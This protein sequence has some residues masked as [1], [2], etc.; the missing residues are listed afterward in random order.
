MN[1]FYHGDCKFVMNHDI[2]AE[3]VDL[4][5]LDPPFFTGQVQRGT[6]KWEPGAMEISYKDTKSYWAEHLERMRQKAPAWMHSIPRSSEFKSYLFYMLERLEACKR[7]LKETGSI[8]L[9]CDWRA[10]HYLKMV[11]DGVFGEDNFQNEVVWHYHSGAGTPKRFGRKHDVILF[12]SKSQTW[13]FNADKVRVPYAPSTLARLKYNGAREHNTEKVLA[14]GG[15]FANDVWSIE[16]V[17]GNTKEHAGYPT[18]KPLALLNRIILASSNEGDIVLDPFCGCGTAIIEAHNNNRKWIGIDIN[19][20]AWKVLHEK[21]AEQVPLT[22]SGSFKEATYVS[23]DIDEVNTLN[24]RD[25]EKWANQFLGAIKPY[26]DH[27]VDGITQDGIPIQVK[28]NPI[29]RPIISQLLTDADLHTKVPKPIKKI[30]VV[31]QTEFD[32]SARE[33]KYQIQDRGI[34]VVLLTPADMLKD[35]DER[36]S[37][38]LS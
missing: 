20:E 31:S 16:H 34:K 9:H 5:Y 7:V 11:M 36:V 10:S 25:F 27:G 6:A 24:E 3:S 37:N 17:Q 30:I 29:G 15:R 33:A 26:P 14:R 38:E 1:T 2:P 35:D 32:N 18:Q 8:Y 13:F 28:T 23:R 12:Y 19:K 4:I 21:R 22:L